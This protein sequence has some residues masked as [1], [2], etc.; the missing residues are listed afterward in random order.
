MKKQG[1]GREK[2]PGEDFDAELTPR[3]VHNK[4]VAKGLDLQ[5]D[6]K[7]KAYCDMDGCLIRDEFGQPL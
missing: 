5:Y 2:K 7:K 4:E 1:G 3:N 6:P